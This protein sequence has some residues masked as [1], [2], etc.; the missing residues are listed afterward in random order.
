MVR[1]IRNSL[2]LIQEHLPL[3]PSVLISA[4]DSYILLELAAQV[5]HISL[6]RWASS[7][8]LRAPAY[9]SRPVHE[10]SRESTCESEH[11]QRKQ[12]RQCQVIPLIELARRRREGG[13]GGKRRSCGGGVGGGVAGGVRGRRR[14]GRPA[15]RASGGRP[16]G[17]EPAVREQVRDVPDGVHVGAA[18][19]YPQVCKA[20]FRRQRP[21]QY[22]PE[23]AAREEALGQ[24]CSVALDIIA[25]LANSSS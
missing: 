1:G 13:D 15:G 7:S 8:R 11:T 2:L 17:H 24:L 23:L 6:P 10:S 18:A 5:W 25:L 21:G 9:I 19:E 16:A 14:R 22:P 12:A 4:A 20:L 3:Q